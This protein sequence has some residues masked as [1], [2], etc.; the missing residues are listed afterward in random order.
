MILKFHIEGASRELPRYDYATYV[1][2][3]D[4]GIGT[5]GIRKA[6]PGQQPNSWAVYLCI[7]NSYGGERDRIAN[8]P[9]ED[10]AARMADV[11][12]DA[13]CHI[14]KSIEATRKSKE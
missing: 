1:P 13:L 11:L 3:V 10:L 12:N 9:T 5:L 2:C 6:E 7:N 8:L 14:H 4:R